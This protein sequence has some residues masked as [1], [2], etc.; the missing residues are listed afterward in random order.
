MLV[1]LLL[2]LL[3]LA[4][5][6]QTTQSFSDDFHSRT[7]D[8]THWVIAKVN[9]RGEVAPT[10]AGLRLAFRVLQNSAPFFAL[11][12]WLNCRVRGDFDARVSFRLVD[13]PFAN[14]IR[15][16][17][18]VSPNIA[19]LPL[20]ATSLHG[21]FGDARGLRTVISE[22]ISLK[23][24]ADGAHPNEIG[25]FYVAELNGRENRLF[26]AFR[27]V[28]KLRVSRVANDFTAWYWDKT[29]GLWVPT[30]RWSVNPQLKDDEWVALQLWG[31]NES[32]NITVLL[33]DFSVSAQD[34]DCP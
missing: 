11:T 8:R 29:G 33:E 4:L 6:A 10:E 34:L 3:G 25:E 26:P 17:L 5:P 27:R 18:G 12:I 20:A 22:R 21:V 13:W 32:P 2:A 24:G 14:G 1:G 15:L 30:G 9:A 7:L 19:S 31:R 23:R 28:G 16:G